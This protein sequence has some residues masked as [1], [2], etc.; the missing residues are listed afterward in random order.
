MYNL[1]FRKNRNFVILLFVMFIFNFGYSSLIPIFPVYFKSHGMTAIMV[2][3]L[4]SLYAITKALV[5]IPSSFVLD[6]FYKD[7]I[8][9]FCFLLFGI[10]FIFYYLSN[11][12]I[13]FAIIRFIEGVVAGISFPVIYSLL[14]SNIK[15]NKRGEYMG[16]FTTISSLGLAVGP[17]LTGM[18]IKLNIAT[19]KTFLI[20]AILSFLGSGLI[21]VFY[22][23]KDEIFQKNI[24]DN[25]EH[26]MFSFFKN[27]FVFLLG[28]GII[29]FIGDFIFSSIS[30]SVPMIFDNVY[31][32]SSEYGAFLLSINFIVF[33]FFSPFAGKIIDKLGTEKCLNF[34]I[35]GICIL[36]FIIFIIENRIIFIILLTLEFFFASLLFTSNQVKAMEL[37]TQINASGKIFAIVGTFQSIGFSVGPLLTGVTYDYNIKFSF[38]LTSI[39]MGVIL[40]VRMMFI[41][42][43]NKV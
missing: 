41:K 43:Y 19:N 22:D 39:L 37:E 20:A 6:K 8:L 32:G 26:S 9:E 25:E 29:G 18:F 17:L 38:L 28:V 35:I 21:Y 42:S 31:S 30:M 13:S 12:V 34:S 36:F 15:Q 4:L 7:R 16:I 1:F 3:F 40:F 5:H 27:N 14:S 2:G 11:K 10:L 33:T 23:H 24:Y